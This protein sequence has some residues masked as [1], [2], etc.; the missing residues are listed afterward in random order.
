[1]IGEAASRLRRLLG[2]FR[3]STSGNTLALVALAFIPV[4]VGMM[5]LVIDVGNARIVQRKLQIAADAAALAGAND[6]GST[7]V[8]PSATATSYSTSNLTSL[9]ALTITPA[10]SF[11]CVNE[12]AYGTCVY[13]AKYNSGNST[14]SNNITVTETT[15]VPTIF[16]RYFGLSTIPVSV[17][18]SAIA[19]R[20][21]IACLLALAPTGA[22]AFTSIGVIQ[23]Y[24]GC[25]IQVNSSDAKAM[26][27]SLAYITADF[28][29]IVGGLS[30]GFLSGLGNGTTLNTGSYALGDPYSG[31]YTANSVQTLQSSSCNYTNKSVTS[32]ATLS[33]GTYCNGLSINANT[34]LNPGVYVIKGGTLS[35]TGG[36]VTGSGVT[37]VLT[38]TPP[39]HTCATFNFN[40]GS[41]GIT[42]PTTGKWSGILI[43]QDSTCTT[44]QTSQFTAGIN[45]STGAIYLPTEALSFLA[46]AQVTFNCAPVVAYT[47]S[48]AVAI[49]ANVSCNGTGVLPVSV[50][51]GAR[52]VG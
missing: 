14:P 13:S 7:T 44:G 33:A 10:V 48:F 47:L 9:S 42:A 3:R 15:T 32:T 21:D 5:A 18:S 16:A 39:S 35:V 4:A 24:S 51:K 28:V 2:R 49:T 50:S 29:N 40:G 1:M 12:A 23:V 27:I 31:L 8:D 22:N 26:S 41:S 25:G 11:S 45:L 20:T 46:S 43:Y 37:F 38:S 36:V 34:T 17:S 19:N 30:Q 52:L 6:I